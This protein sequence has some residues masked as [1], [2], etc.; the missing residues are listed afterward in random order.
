MPSFKLPEQR[1][2]VF[3]DRTTWLQVVKSQNSSPPLLQDLL[4]KEKPLLSKSGEIRKKVGESVKLKM[5]FT[6]SSEMFP[7]LFVVNR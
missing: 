5:Y 4:E 6:K 2:A 1:R 3:L 7:R